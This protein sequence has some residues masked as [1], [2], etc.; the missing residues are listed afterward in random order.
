[1]RRLRARLPPG[2]ALPGSRWREVLREKELRVASTGDGLER[3]YAITSVALEGDVLVVIDRHWW[4]TTPALARERALEA[5]AERVRRAVVILGGPAQM[6]D[7]L[8]VL[9]RV[10]VPAIAGAATVARIDMAA[11]ALDLATLGRLAPLLAMA[12]PLV[13][14]RLLL[15][16]ARRAMR[17]YI[18]RLLGRLPT[19]GQPRAR[20]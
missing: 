18:R 16:P 19:L 13:P 5:H 10:T 20:L 11:L 15:F 9:L 17:W 7:K 8:A 6:L 2:P 3:P 1:M 4:E 12:T 14:R